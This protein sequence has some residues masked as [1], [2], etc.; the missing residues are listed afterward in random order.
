MLG[1]CALKYFP[2]RVVQSKGFGA[3]VPDNRLLS[4][5]FHWSTLDII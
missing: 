5:F 3:P 4:I 2:K 1:I